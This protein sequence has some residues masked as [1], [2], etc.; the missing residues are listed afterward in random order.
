MMSEHKVGVDF[1][2]GED[3]RNEVRK[4]QDEKWSSAVQDGR[5][6][7]SHRETSTKY[8]H[9]FI[10][11][12]ADYNLIEYFV[13][14]VGDTSNKLS[15]LNC[16]HPIFISYSYVIPFA[17]ECIRAIVEFAFGGHGPLVTSIVENYNY[18][19]KHF[20]SKLDDN[21]LFQI[22]IR[23]RPMLNYDIETG[24]YD[25]LG[26]S[27]NTPFTCILHDGRLARNGR[28]LMMSHRHYTLSHCFDETA[29]NHEVC[30]RVVEPLIEHIMQGK[31]STLLCY[32]QTGSSN[33]LSSLLLY[34]SVCGQVLARR[35]L[36]WALSGTYLVDWR[37]DT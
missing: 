18:N 26:L 29:S 28:Q 34:S 1:E 24:A 19:Y 17:D 14:A 32:G 8:R 37:G 23:K 5:S 27:K 4:Q 6:H 11:S 16:M 2:L 3:V 9:Q 21:S 12:I 13:N 10:N 7:L 31:N 36:L 15:V 25:V 20:H 22:F 33:Q 35:I 30:E